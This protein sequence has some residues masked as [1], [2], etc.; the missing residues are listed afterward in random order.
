MAVLD[1]DSEVKA[2]VENQEHD[3]LILLD[4]NTMTSKPDKTRISS[5]H[6]SA[7][8]IKITSTVKDKDV[9]ADESVNLL[10]SKQK[11]TSADMKI[12]DIGDLAIFNSDKTSSKSDEKKTISKLKNINIKEKQKALEV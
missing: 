5:K 1:S 3:C 2:T 9:A 7:K 8:N 10:S 12:T 6:V 11:K 4:S